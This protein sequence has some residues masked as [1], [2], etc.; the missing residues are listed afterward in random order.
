MLHPGVCLAAHSAVQGIGITTRTLI[1]AGSVVW[2]ME[3][4]V[5]HEETAYLYVT[6]REAVRYVDTLFSGRKADMLF[7]GMP[8]HKLIK[9]AIDL[10]PFRPVLRE[11][12]NFTQSG[13]PP[14][15][16]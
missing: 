12:Y 13:R 8:R 2:H 16:A 4:T 14:R 11:F 15:S 10:P 5:G 9:L 1:R 7:A 6:T 3:D